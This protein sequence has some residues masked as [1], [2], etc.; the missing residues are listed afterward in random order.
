MN[1]S[2]IG[3]TKKSSHSKATTYIKCNQPLAKASSDSPCHSSSISPASITS[4][5]PHMQADVNDKD[6]DSLSVETKSSK[7]ALD[8]TTIS[9]AVPD[10][11]VG[12]PY[13]GS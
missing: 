7:K 11:Y 10:Y 12:I 4:K 3:A 5:V 6:Q 9:F 2:F 13:D 1:L 8:N